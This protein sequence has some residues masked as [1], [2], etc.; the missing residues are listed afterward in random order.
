M[1]QAWSTKWLVY[2]CRSQD[3]TVSQFLTISLITTTTEH[4]GDIVRL[5]LYTGL[6]CLQWE[7]IE[8]VLLNGRH[9]EQKP[10]M[11]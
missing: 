3:V 6:E 10:P 11:I 2:S 9:N 7:Y 4:T 1:G 5:K 8:L